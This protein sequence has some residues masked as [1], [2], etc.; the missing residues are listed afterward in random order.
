MAVG[1]GRSLFFPGPGFLRKVREGRVFGFLDPSVI[2]GVAFGGARTGTWHDEAAETGRDQV[3]TAPRPSASRG[4]WQ[5]D[6]ERAVILALLPHQKGQSVRLVSYCSPSVAGAAW[7]PGRLSGRIDG[8]RGDS[9]VEKA[10]HE[11]QPVSVKAGDWSRDGAH[12][13]ASAPLE[14]S[15]PEADDKQPGTPP[16]SRN[17]PPAT[18][19]LARFGE[20]GNVAS[21]HRTVSAM[22][23]RRSADP[24]TAP[25]LDV[26]SRSDGGRRSFGTEDTDRTIVTLHFHV[27]FDS[28]G[29]W[30]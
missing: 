10:R 14:A 1:G 7:V 18:L 2:K 22:Q 5:E 11:P 25:F 16:R 23:R 29:P 24:E 13:R 26:D 6:G 4:D 28:P 27:L 12:C 19:T 15:T 3:G 17:S 30:H 8:N 9:S 21:G 20:G